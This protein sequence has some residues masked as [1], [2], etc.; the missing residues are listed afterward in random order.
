M[1]AEIDLG[2]GYMRVVVA[3]WAGESSRCEDPAP[4]VGIAGRP[5]RGITPGYHKASA[6][7]RQKR[8]GTPRRDKEF[9]VG[10]QQIVTFL[11]IGE[12]CYCLLGRGGVERSECPP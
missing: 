9:S 7:A 2:G 1:R 12:I 8:R 11:S 3:Q 6:M 4:T 5:L 10:F